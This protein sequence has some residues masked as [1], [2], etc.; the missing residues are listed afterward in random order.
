MK[1]EVKEQIT[2]DIEAWEYMKNLPQ[3]WHGFTFAKL[4]YE[5]GDMLDLYSYENAA[6]RRGIT[7]YY[8]DETKEY[9]LRMRTGLTEFCVIEYIYAKLSDFE[10]I[11]LKRCENLLIAM[12]QFNAEH[13]TS[14]VHDKKIMQWDYHKLVPETLEGFSL[15]ISPD[16]PVRGINGSYIIFDY[17]DFANQSNFIIYYNV[18]RDEFFGESRIFNIP[19]V[20][21]AFDAHE[22]QELIGKLELKLVSHM[23][24]L[25]ERINK[26]K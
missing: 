20:S 12:A 25:R 3:E 17:S 9:K 11:L 26:G 1:D 21:Y 24:S 6:L 8:H 5:H 23:Q 10:D 4:M 2:A 13:I 18:F 16:K 22:L 7:I 15:F 19:E 14:I